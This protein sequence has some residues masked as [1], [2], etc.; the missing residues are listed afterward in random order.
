VGVPIGSR[1]K[2]RKRKMAEIPRGAAI[3]SPGCESRKKGA[4]NPRRL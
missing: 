4:A 1:A 2:G 3:W